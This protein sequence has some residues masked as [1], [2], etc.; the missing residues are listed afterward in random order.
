MSVT[1]DSFRLSFPA[2]QNTVL[3]PAPFVEFWL[4]QA[5]KLH[6]ADRWGDCLDFGVMLWTAHNIILEAQ[7]GR[8]AQAGRATSGSTGVLASKSVDNVSASYDNSVAKEEGAGNWNLTTYGQRWYRLSQMAG[9]GPL[10][11]GVP[12]ASDILAGGGAWPGYMY[13]PN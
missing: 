9:A 7:A 2:F 3:Y 13:P 4:G 11:S 6:N 5:L 12:S 8:Q 1:A 10:Q